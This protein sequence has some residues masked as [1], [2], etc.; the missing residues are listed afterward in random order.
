MKSLSMKV[1]LFMFYFFPTFPDSSDGVMLGLHIISLFLP[2]V[3]LH[4]F[5][6]DALGLFVP[7][8]GRSGADIIPDVFV[9]LLVTLGVIILTSYHVSFDVNPRL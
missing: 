5:L 6:H 7:I 1:F 3:V 8:M 4:H 2:C 9:G